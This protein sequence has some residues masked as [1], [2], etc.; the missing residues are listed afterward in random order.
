MA[1]SDIDAIHDTW[2]QG[3]EKRDAALTAS[4]YAPD[5]HVLPPGTEAVTGDGIRAYWQGFLDMGVTGGRLE[6]VRFEES[7]DLAVEEGR[8]EVLNGSEV[9]DY[10]KY[11]DVSRRQ[12]DGS[13][14]LIIDI[15]NS[16][17]NPE[18]GA[19]D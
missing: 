2:L 4:V 7:D 14:K 15:F 9:L 1:R 12:P 13:W 8:Y 18:A 11:V 10:G 19:T 5:A 16:S 6:S 17:Q 3:F